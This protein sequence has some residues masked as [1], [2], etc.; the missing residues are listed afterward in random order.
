MC[1]GEKMTSVSRKPRLLFLAY[2]F[3]PIN[4][5]GC[6]RAYNIAKWLTRVG[7]EVTVVTPNESA[8]RQGRGATDL[9]ESLSRQ[10]VRCMRTEHRWRSLLPVPSDRRG[11]AWAI[12]GV[13]RRI[14]SFLGLERETGWLRQ[15]EKACAGLR[16]EDVDVVFVSGPPFA[17]FELAR[18]VAGRLGRPFVMDYRDLWTGNPHARRPPSQPRIEAERATLAAASAATG[19]S[20]SLLESLRQQFG[21]ETGL[22]VISNG[23]DP[24]EMIGVPGHGF[25]HFAIV[26]AGVFYPPKRTVGP[27]MAALR[28][29]EQLVPASKEWFFHY[30]GY[31]SE[32][33]LEVARAFDI[34]RRLVIHGNVPRPE[35]LSAVRGANVAVVIS[36]VLE[37]A[38]LQDK[39]IVTGK[40]FEAVGLGTRLLV[41]A[42][43]GSDLEGVLATTGLG[44]R[45][46]GADVEGMA[47]YLRDVMKGEGPTDFRPESFSWANIV[48]KLDGVLRAAV[49]APPP[50]RSFE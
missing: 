11:L 9:H 31:Q 46:S 41:I 29:L 34:E 23:F 48:Q 8:W 32:Y 3:P 40:V 14:A 27:L 24:E 25:A 50:E 20:S 35:A 1:G 49:S 38:S 47:G 28:R 30:Y 19:V 37:H 22:H 15:A 4:N 21:G 12:G 17:S 39:G 5:I 44:R 13:S 33:V 16:P 10:G 2:D 45:F 6:V 18:R 26:Y 42:P 43:E 7:W 36:S